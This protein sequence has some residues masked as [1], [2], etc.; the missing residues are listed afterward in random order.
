MKIHIK[1]MVCDRCIMVVRQELE[2]LHLNPTVV[3]LGV[4]EIGVENLDPIKKEL[5][6][7][8]LSLGFELLQDKKDQTVER[9]KNL[10]VHLIHRDSQPLK[11][12]LSEYLVA[13][14]NQDYSSL[15]HLF[16]E[17]EHQSIEKFFIQQKIEKVKELL[18]YGEFTLSEIAFQLHYSSVAH[19]SNQF[20]K[21]VGKSPSVYRK[22][23]FQDRSTLDSL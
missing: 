6:E 5:Q 12:K 3:E 14:F 15:S 7:R 9:I 8:M 13:E 1:N 20:K 4:A 11:I 2:K 18:S 22:E 19:L 16:T 23:I 21:V 10:L 17:H